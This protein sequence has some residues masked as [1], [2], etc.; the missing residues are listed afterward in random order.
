MSAIAKRIEFQDKLMIAAGF[1]SGRSYPSLFELLGYRKRLAEQILRS[2][3]SEMEK[4]YQEVYEYTNDQ[5]KALLG[6]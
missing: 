4:K 1:D 5:I 3:S 2:N 6:L